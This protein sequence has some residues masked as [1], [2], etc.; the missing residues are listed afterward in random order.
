MW[1]FVGS[2][3]IAAFKSAIEAHRG[4]AFGAGVA[5][6]M[7]HGSVALA[8]T[9]GSWV[10][11]D[12]I[13]GTDGLMPVYGAFLPIDLFEPA[14]GAVLGHAI[15]CYLGDLLSYRQATADLSR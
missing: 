11:R 13:D 5:T 14:Y 1:R 15:G 2:T 10:L 9:L 6:D 4:R 12:R 8:S 3:G 7:E